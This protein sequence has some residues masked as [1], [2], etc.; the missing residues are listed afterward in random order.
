MKKDKKTVFSEEIDSS[1]NGYALGITFLLLS[2]F[3][4]LKPDYFIIPMVSYIV[5]TLLG[6]TGII[7]CSLEISKSIEIKGMDTL[8]L[9]CIFVGI[10]FGLNRLCPNIIVN[11]FAFFILMF[12]I[13]GTLRGNF[14]LVYSLLSMKSKKTEVDKMITFKNIFLFIVQ[15]AG[16]VLTVLNIINLLSL[17]MSN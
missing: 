5:G 16:F 1:I 10:W 12:G 4:I 14:E 2:V 11:I 6:I 15:F 9:G 8:S 3:T 17:L 13:Y 7:G